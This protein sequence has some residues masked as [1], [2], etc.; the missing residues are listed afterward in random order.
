[1]LGHACA[2]SAVLRFHTMTPFAASCHSLLICRTD[3]AGYVE[4]IEANCLIGIDF[5]TTWTL[6][7]PRLATI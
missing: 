4:A 3:A 2:L 5:V 6:C 7:P 1:M